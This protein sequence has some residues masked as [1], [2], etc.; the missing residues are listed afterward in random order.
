M[1]TLFTLS[2]A[3]LAEDAKDLIYE[4]IATTSASF[5]STA[6]LNDAK[7]LIYEGIATPLIGRPNLK[8]GASGRQRP[9]LRRDCDSR[10]LRD[11][12]STPHGVDAK[13][14]IYEGIATC[15]SAFPF[16]GRKFRDAKDLIYE[17]IATGFITSDPFSVLLDAKDL[18]YE[19][20]ATRRR[21]FVL[22]AEDLDAKDLIYEGIA[23]RLSV[24]Q[25]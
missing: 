13:D 2:T 19:G 7:D 10:E 1:V 3:S 21:S 23:T 14:L 22:P 4:G 15:R 16:P 9:D 20:I 18:I 11:K 8:P 5:K 6:I 12:L 17:G 24:A 25:T